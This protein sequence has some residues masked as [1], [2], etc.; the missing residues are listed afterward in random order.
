LLDSKGKIN[1]IEL[2]CPLKEGSMRS[3]RIKKGVERAP[4]RSLLRALGFSDDDLKKPLIGIANLLQR[5]HPR[6]HPFKKP[7]RGR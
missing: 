7:C 2:F 1:I 6:A 3:D 5:D 4:H